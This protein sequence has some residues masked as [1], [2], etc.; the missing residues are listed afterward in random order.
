MLA[1]RS[2]KSH[3]NNLLYNYNAFITSKGLAWA[4][5]GYSFK[6]TPIMI[7]KLKRV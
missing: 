2:G 4:R 1:R 6:N 7:E 5:F 3:K